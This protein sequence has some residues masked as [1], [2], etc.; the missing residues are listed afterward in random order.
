MS[1]ST[2]AEGELEKLESTK[3]EDQEWV[4]L[5]EENLI[6]ND[7]LVTIKYNELDEGKQTEEELKKEQKKK[8]DEPFM[9]K[10]IGLVNVEEIEFKIKTLEQWTKDLLSHCNSSTAIASSFQED[11]RR[12]SKVQQQLHLAHFREK[13]RKALKKLSTKTERREEE[14]VEVP[15]VVRLG[16]LTLF[17]LVEALSSL[18]DFEPSYQILCQKILSVLLNVL[19][20]L[21]PLALHREPSDCLDAFADFCFNSIK[22]NNYCIDSPDKTQVCSALT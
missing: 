15:V 17:P 2:S 3:E 6:L 1:G 5:S 16:V 9:P 21:P 19:S 22:K 12:K 11:L 4:T 14:T 7:T 13:K 10:L 20:T 18:K 8:S